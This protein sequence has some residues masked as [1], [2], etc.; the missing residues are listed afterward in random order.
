MLACKMP[1]S[2]GQVLRV[3]VQIYVE[4]GALAGLADA[5]RRGRMI[6]CKTCGQ[7]GATLGCHHKSCR[8]SYHL[9]CARKSNCLV[10]ARMDSDRY[11][12]HAASIM[13]SLCR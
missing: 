9:D 10:Q 13:F 11:V 8:L 7:K 1:T 6:K 5:V 2:S 4:H 12:L 3:C